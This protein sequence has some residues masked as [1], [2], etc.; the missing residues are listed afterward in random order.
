MQNTPATKQGAAGKE[1]GLNE[2]PS[3]WSHGKS[4]VF[5]EEKGTGKG[6]GLG[7][8]EGATRK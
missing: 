8:E 7:K 2:S 6:E 3:T 4:K 1:G 5:W